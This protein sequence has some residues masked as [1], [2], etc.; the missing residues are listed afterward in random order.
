MIVETESYFTGYC[1]C[2]DGSR[3]VTAEYFDG[4]WEI[5]CSYGSCPYEPVCPIAGDLRCLIADT[6]A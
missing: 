1:R 2:L 5:D 3:M 4:K 6:E